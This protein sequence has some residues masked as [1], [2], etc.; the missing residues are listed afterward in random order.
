S[1]HPNQ[2]AR[3]AHHREVLLKAAEQVVH[4]GGQGVVRQQ[5]AEARDHHVRRWYAGQSYSLAFGRRLTRRPKPDEHRNEHQEWIVQREQACNT[6]HDCEELSYTCSDLG[7]FAVR[8]A[9]GD[10]CPQH[11][12]AVHREGGYHVEEGE[13]HVHPE[14]PYHEDAG[15][16]R[17]SGHELPA[18][19]V[20]AHNSEYQPDGHRE[21]HVHGGTG[22]GDRKRLHRFARQALEACHAA[23][24]QQGDVPGGNAVATG[25]ERVSEFVQHDYRE[26]R[27]NEN[28]AARRT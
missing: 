3:L 18:E 23:N 9:H 26:H 13:N 19:R 11:T 15:E 12:P 27:E 24:R 4:S 10:Q 22:K 21:H 8:L 28:H 6:E 25:G 7:G 2:L 14:Q 16:Q 5:R 20:Y 17:V 1:E